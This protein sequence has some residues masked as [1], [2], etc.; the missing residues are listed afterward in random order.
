M[1]I[2]MT[3]L[4]AASA[5]A[6]IALSAPLS[7]ALSLTDIA[8]AK[9]GGGN[10]GGKGGGNG[11]GNSGGKG[12]GKG[13][14]SGS[15]SHSGKSASAG[16]SQKSVS[17]DQET[18]DSGR[19]SKDKSAAGALNAAHASA[20]ARARAAPNS[21]VGRIASYEQARDQALAV[22]DPAE[23]DAQLA[24]AVSDLEVAIGTTLTEA[25]V[26]KINALLDRD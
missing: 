11:G 14:Q 7:G 25:Q 12:G 8:Y 26:A 2:T 5:I 4:A 16:K 18:D 24:N 20:R 6:V 23:R 15:S 21:A 1:K 22:A 10:G 9:D 13:G 3:R 17:A 19:A